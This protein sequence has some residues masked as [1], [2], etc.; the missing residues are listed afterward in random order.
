M[1]DI[2]HGLRYH[3]LYG[4]WH[5][6]RSRCSNTKDKDYPRYGGRGIK[7]CERWDNFALFLADM[8]EKPS[9]SHSID[10]IDNNGNYEPANCR[11]AT[12]SQQTHN[13]KVS[14]M[15]VQKIIEIRKTYEQNKTSQKCLSI[16]YGVHQSLISR[17]VSRKIWRDIP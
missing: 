15:T 11:W 8:G 7:V 4:T 9:S 10:R 3:S 1:Q 2:K 16:V 14:K 6:M 5:G 17:I 12:R 13:S